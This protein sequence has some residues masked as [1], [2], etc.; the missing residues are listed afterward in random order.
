MTEKPIKMEM[1]ILICHYLYKKQHQFA[2][3][4]LKGTLPTM[5]DM[6][7]SRMKGGLF[8]CFTYFHLIIMMFIDF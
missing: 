7:E 8:M 6:I 4:D 2:R 5:Y 1:I 3:N